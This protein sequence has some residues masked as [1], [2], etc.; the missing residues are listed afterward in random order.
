MQSTYYQIRSLAW[1]GLAS[2][3][4]VQAAS[5]APSAAQPYDLS[6]VE[7]VQ[8]AGSDAA[9]AAFQTNV[10]PGM[11]ATVQ[12]Q[13]PDN[14]HLNAQALAAISLDPTKLVLSADSTARVYFLGQDAGYR[15][16]LGISNTGSP[17]TPGAA[18]I[19]PGALY[20]TGANGGSSTSGTNTNSTLTAGDFV[21]L[22]N[23]KAGT[24]LDFFLLGN[25][26]QKGEF[27]STTPSLNKDGIIHAVNLAPNGSAY[28]L[29]GFEDTK[30]GGSNDFNDFLFAV[31]ISGASTTNGS[32]L[33]SLGAPEPSLALG[34]LL[35]GGALFGFSRRRMA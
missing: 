9:A 18:L 28:L 32:K 30:G 1:L 11:L 23:L 6:I 13:L 34:A 3:L 31:E 29:I 24:A 16:T 2:L 10:L 17:L 12:Q 14:G 5:A 7:P 19:F 35:A 4:A 26:A 33:I 27:F 22:G 21:D 8:V 20:T 25:N 15:D